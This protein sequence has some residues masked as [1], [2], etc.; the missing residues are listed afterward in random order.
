MADFPS[1]VAT[2]ITYAFPAFPIQSHQGSQ[3]NVDFWTGQYASGATV[4][5]DFAHQYNADWDAVVDHHDTHENKTFRIPTSGWQA[6]DNLFDIYASILS[7][8]YASPPSSQKAGALYSIRAQ[9]EVVLD[10]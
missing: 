7:F 2:S 3:G 8:R 5:V 1:L 6:H 10:N 4:T 9:F